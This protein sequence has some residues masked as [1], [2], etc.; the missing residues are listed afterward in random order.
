MERIEKEDISVGSGII[1]TYNRMPQKLERVFAE[2]IDNTMQ[3]YDDHHEEL[4]KILGESPCKI[5]IIWNDSEIIIKDEA[6]GM[7]H[8][9]FKRALKLNTP[10][11]KYSEKSRSQYGMGLKIAAAYLGNWY[12]I[13]STQYGNKEKYYSIIDIDE[14]KKSNPTHIDCNISDVKAINHFTEIVIKKLNKKL[15]AAVDISLRKKLAKIYSNDI[16]KNRLEIIFNGKPI[17]SEDPELRKNPETDNDYLSYFEDSFEFN[18]ENFTYSGWVGILKTADV[19]D[20][21][22]TLSQYGRGIKLNYRPTQVFGKSNSFPYQRI[23]G[24]IQLDD[25]KWKISFNK[26][27]F[28]WD[29][30]LEKEFIKSLKGNQDINEMIGIAKVLRK[31]IPSVPSVEQKDVKKVA[32]K[33][34]KK[35]EGLSSV[36]TT[37]VETPS[38]DKPTVIIKKNEEIEPVIVNITWESIDYTFDIQVKNDNKRLDWFNLQRKECDT[39]NA[40]YIIIN[41]LS[42]HFSEYQKKE[43]KDLIIDFAVMLALT[44]LSSERVG[45]DPEKSSALIH[46]LNRIVEN[47]KNPD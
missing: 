22:F 17:Q 35:Y 6:F 15:T 32:S 10:K 33:I 14:W 27:E 3:S 45:V 5:I 2:F 16:T 11:V 31:D 12:S 41:G 38:S 44:Q 34:E 43:C 24:E 46:Q 42:P 28:I 25:P 9:D 21:G 47:A 30:G 23:V 26:D 8:E 1:A 18:G 29:D 40:Y 37:V 36:K 13:D 20:A 7:D 19:E 39:E 4:E